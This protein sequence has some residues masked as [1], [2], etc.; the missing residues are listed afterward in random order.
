M[1]ETPFGMLQRS[2]LTLQLFQFL[3]P[4]TSLK[5]E[6]KGKYTWKVEA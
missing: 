4:T 5:A 2:Y 1:L 6:M 3:L